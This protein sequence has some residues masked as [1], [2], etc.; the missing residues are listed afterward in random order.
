MKDIMNEM[1]NPNI[2]LETG[3]SGDPNRS[4]LYL[5]PK[6]YPYSVDLKES[7]DSIVGCAILDTCS[8][9]IQRVFFSCNAKSHQQLRDETSLKASY[10]ISHPEDYFARSGTC[11]HGFYTQSGYFLDRVQALDMMVYFGITIHNC[12]KVHN[13]YGVTSENIWPLK[14]PIVSQAS[15]FKTGPKTVKQMM[16]VKRLAKL[17]KKVNRRLGIK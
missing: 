13:R 6:D 11:I 1:L 15:G 10:R 12:D 17:N 14:K 4:E 16:E 2:P 8:D 3:Y 7:T 9:F 5:M